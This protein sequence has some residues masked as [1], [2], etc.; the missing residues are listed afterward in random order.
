MERSRTARKQRTRSHARELIRNAGIGL[1]VAALVAAVVLGARAAGMANETAPVTASREA[2]Q[3]SVLATPIAR[4]LD[5]STVVEVPFVTGKRASEAEM[6][7]SYAGFKVVSVGAT[8]S[9]VGS[10]SVVVAQSPRAGVKLTP[11]DQVTLTCASRG[12]TSTAAPRHFVVVLDPGHQARADLSQEPVGP[13]AADSKE[14]ATAGATGVGSKRSESLV[15]LEVALRVKARLE[16]AGV[17]VV[18]TRTTNE[19]NLSNVARAQIAN[20]VGADLFLRIHA[21]AAASPAVKGISTL[22]PGG[23]PW[24]A[25]IAD[26]SKRAARIMQTSVVAGTGSEDRGI[27]EYADLAGFNWSKVPSIL[28]Q[29]GFLS[30]ADDDRLLA[31]PAYQDKLADGIT[32]GVFAYFGG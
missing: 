8:G 12:G 23:S 24:V 27:T 5:T 11:G 17:Q 20:R 1:G 22:Y 4:S 31:D 16:K 25:P 13:G 29:T 3:A 7:L 10:V 21:D 26:R 28:V 14:K 30:S 32:K 19:V 15:T 18:M 6:V 9:V 2:T